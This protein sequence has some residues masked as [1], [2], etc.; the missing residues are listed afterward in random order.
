MG[1]G[2]GGIFL[3]IVE[4]TLVKSGNSRVSRFGMCSL[5]GEGFC[6]FCMDVGVE[7][8]EVDFPIFKSICLSYACVN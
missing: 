2:N 3:L 8:A 4:G 5:G 7:K 1:L 6:L